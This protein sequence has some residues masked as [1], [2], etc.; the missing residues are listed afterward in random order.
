MSVDCGN[1]LA[2]VA[3]YDFMKSQFNRATQTLRQPGSSFKPL[4]YTAALEEGMTPA[5]TV[6]DA[7][8]TSDIAGAK[9]WRPENYD[10]KY[11]GP[12]TLRAAL[13]HS[14][15]L[16]TVRILDK[17]GVPTACATVKRL[18]ITSPMR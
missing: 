5:S 11:H 4:I 10:G 17:V 1:V 18:G 9:G 3:G 14:R 15:N 6:L 16:A 13:T 7:P 8:L 12:V 2:M